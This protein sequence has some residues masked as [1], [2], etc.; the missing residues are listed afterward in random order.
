M[1]EPSLA[2]LRAFVAVAR[3]RHFGIAAGELGVTQPAVSAALRALE[4][5]VG[6][7]LVERSARGVL[8]TPLGAALLPGAEQVLAALDDFVADGVRAGRPHA[9]PLRLGVIPTIAPYLLPTLLAA[10]HREFP[11]IVPEVREGQTRHLLD[12]LLEGA[13]DL[14]VLAL[15]AGRADVVE[16]PLYSEEFVLLVPE[17]DPA[18]G[19]TLAVSDLTSF[20]VLL[21]EEGHCL[22]D[23]TLDVCRQAGTSGRTAQ[24]ASLTTLSQLVAAGLGVTLLPASAVPV[25]VRGTLATAC[26]SDTPAPGRAVGLVHRPTSTRAKEYAELAARLRMAIGAAGLPVHVG[27]AE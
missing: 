5:N 15:P 26:F 19:C 1:S 17:G 21:L 3:E 22:R 16:V 7:R 6:G 13:L 20:D 2:Q 4:A 14:L 11:A 18:A 12:G 23:Q 8:L 27:G 10:L 9:G 25:E 24:A